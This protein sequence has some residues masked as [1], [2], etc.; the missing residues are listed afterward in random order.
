MFPSYRVN[1]V[2]LSYG[3]TEKER[4]KKLSENQKTERLERRTYSK[5]MA[6]YFI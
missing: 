2:P 1:A 5:G 6:F 3:L 4:P